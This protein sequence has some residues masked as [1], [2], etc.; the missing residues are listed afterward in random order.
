MFK[1]WN[2]Q[3]MCNL[4]WL[5]LWFDKIKTKTQSHIREKALQCIE[6]NIPYMYETMSDL[7]NALS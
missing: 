5:V 3:S 7:E 4:E 1:T 6:K 2:K